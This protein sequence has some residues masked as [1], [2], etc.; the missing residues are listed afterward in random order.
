MPEQQLLDDEE[1]RR[2]VLDELEFDPAIEEPTHIG[3]AADN[4][5]VTLTG[6]VSSYPAK[7]AAERAARRVLG[8]RAVA[9]DI[10]VKLPF[11]R[12]RTD[13][14]IATAAVNALEWD[15]VVPSDRIKVT[16][17]DGFVTLEGNVD[18][19]YQKEAAER[20][21]RNL[22]GVRGVANLITV[23]A[24]KVSPEEVKA[25][26]AQALERSA[27][28]DARKI[29]VEA[30]DGRLVLSGTVRSWAER[31][32]A[33]AVAWATRGVSQVENRIIVSP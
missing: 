31:Q 3:V 16:V 28:L 8:V 15:T 30:Y 4:G 9:N 7:F 18:W 21:V 11:E 1:I 2:R 10:E 29:K 5:V 12:T 25:K 23:A 19:Y 13:T 27:E 14:D 22:Q 26:I 33:E 24:P 20:D 17:R 6:T 32:E